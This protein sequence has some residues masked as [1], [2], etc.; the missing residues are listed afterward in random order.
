MVKEKIIFNE[1]YYNNIMAEFGYDPIK[2]DKIDFLL[3]TL[4]CED[5]QRRWL[6]HHD[7]DVFAK[8]TTLARNTIVSTGIGLS[9]VPHAGTLS[10]ILRSIT[11]QN[12]GIPI[13]MVLGD[14]DAYNGKA[15]PLLESLELAERYKNFV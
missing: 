12:A 15:K 9:G 3:G 5:L 13:H 6:C 2:F 10:Q 11:L 14:L 4:S 1:L 7:G 8:D